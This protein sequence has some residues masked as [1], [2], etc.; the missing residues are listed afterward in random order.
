MK[1]FYGNI[2]E[3]N[4]IF[5]EITQKRTFKLKKIIKKGII[6][7]NDKTFLFLKTVSD[8]LFYKIHSKN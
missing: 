2:L 4:T 6:Y 5:W 7:E 1:P 3:D 8:K